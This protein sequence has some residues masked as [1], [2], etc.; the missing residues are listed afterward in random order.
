MQ[1]WKKIDDW[2]K[3]A[4]DAAL[5]ILKPGKKDNDIRLISSYY[6]LKLPY[7]KMYA[8]TTAQANKLITSGRH[9]LEMT[10]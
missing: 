4:R 8:Y 6:K 2:I 9:E 7:R 1:I 3:E 10:Y 5:K